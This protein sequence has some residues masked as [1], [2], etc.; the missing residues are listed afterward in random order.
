MADIY[1]ANIPKIVYCLISQLFGEFEHKKTAKY[2]YSQF[3]KKALRY[4][5]CKALNLFYAFV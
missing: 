1:L 2:F 5:A 4:L 3:I